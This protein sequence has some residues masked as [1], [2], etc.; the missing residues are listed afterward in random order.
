MDMTHKKKL[1]SDYIIFLNPICIVHRHT[2]YIHNHALENVRMLNAIMVISLFC[3]SHHLNYSAG[4]AGDTITL[5][6]VIESES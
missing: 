4:P 5:S 2:Q 6:A 3:L 1:S